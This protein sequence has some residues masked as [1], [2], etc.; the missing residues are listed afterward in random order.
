[1]KNNL[2]LIFINMATTNKDNSPVV[3]KKVSI[4]F[5]V[6]LAVFMITMIIIYGFLTV[7]YQQTRTDESGNTV[8]NYTKGV[9]GTITLIMDTVFTLLGFGLILSPYKNAKWTGMAVA[10]FVVS[11]NIILGLLFQDMW[12]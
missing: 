8:P 7:Y 6:L 12:F 5:S 9:A 2:Y 3:A 1:M 4:V 11:F 10:L